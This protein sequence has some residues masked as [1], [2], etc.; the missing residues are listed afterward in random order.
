MPVTWKGNGDPNSGDN[1]II[2]RFQMR[3][4]KPFGVRFVKD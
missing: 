1:S 3:Q 4:A 2:L